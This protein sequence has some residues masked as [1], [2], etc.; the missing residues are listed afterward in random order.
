MKNKNIL[1]HELVLEEIM[2]S[3]GIV[4]DQFAEDSWPQNVIDA[5]ELA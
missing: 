5:I 4:E 2:K 3:C 1:D